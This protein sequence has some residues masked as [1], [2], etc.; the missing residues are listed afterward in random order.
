MIKAVIFDMDGVMIDSE[1]LW[2]KTEKIIMARKGL[3]YTPVYR[4]KIVGLG[5]K[6]S[7]KLLKDTFSLDDEIEDIINTR[8]SILLDIYDKE[9]EL[10]YGL[11]NLLNLLS[12]KPVG[13]ALAS[14]SPKRVID[15][16]LGKFGLNSY[17][18][19]VVSGDFVENGKPHPEIYLHTA[20]LLSLKPGECVVIEDS[21]NGVR[22]S[23]SAGMYCVAVPDK[24]LD[25]TGFIDADIRV[26]KLSDID[27]GMLLN[28]SSSLS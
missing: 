12:E 1:P 2:E 15:F 13:V 26:D 19:P 11:I 25:P 27:T 8:I 16:V 4:E 7:A 18:E 14:S 17:F 6:D 23:K 22:S 5:Q 20:E 9:L 3:V 28:F 10:V 24:R 21:I